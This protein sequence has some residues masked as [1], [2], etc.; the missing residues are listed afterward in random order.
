MSYWEGWHG[1]AL[2]PVRDVGRTKE[3]DEEVGKKKFRA[4]KDVKSVEMDR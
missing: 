2:E 4:G 1:S 3:T